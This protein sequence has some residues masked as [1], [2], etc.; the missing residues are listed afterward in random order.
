MRTAGLGM[1]LRGCT[2]CWSQNC[3]QAS[4]FLLSCS[5]KR[6]V[7]AL[8]SPSVAIGVVGAAGSGLSSAGSR[9]GRQCPLRT[10][11]NACLSHSDHDAVVLVHFR[12]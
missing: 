1:S 12:H 11:P 6:P 7:A 5:S 9:S 3:P 2:P 4:R 10:D 8:D